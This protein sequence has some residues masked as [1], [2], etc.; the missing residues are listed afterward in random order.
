MIPNDII[1]KILLYIGELNHTLIITQ[2]DNKNKEYYMINKHA[3][4]ITRIKVNIILKIKYPI[5]NFTNDSF[6]L[7]RNAIPHEKYVHLYK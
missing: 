6:R 7:Y 5:F 1:N 3:K 2:Y 4:I